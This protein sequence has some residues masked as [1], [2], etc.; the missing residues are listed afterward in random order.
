MLVRAARVAKDGISVRVAYRDGTAAVVRVHDAD[1]Q[2]FETPRLAGDG[3]TLGWRVF[4]RTAIGRGDAYELALALR[5]FRKGVVD[6]EVGCLET[7]GGYR[8]VLDWHFT[9]AAAQVVVT[10]SSVGALDAGERLLF[11]VASGTQLGQVRV[12]CRGDHCKLAWQ[13]AA[14]RPPAWARDLPER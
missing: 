1:A 2:F 14:G 7:D 3:Q 8:T 9:A 12:G 5:V 10:C 13:A 11:D 4:T 6:Q